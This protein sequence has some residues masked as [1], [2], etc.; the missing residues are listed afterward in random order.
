VKVQF[1]FTATELADVAERSAGRSVVLQERRRLGVA[2]WA[3]L[4]SFALFFALVG[5][6]WTRLLYSILIFI[7]LVL[8][9]PYVFPS[10]LRG[11]YRKYYREQLGGD[12]PFMCEVEIIPDG[13][14]C[15]Q[16]GVEIKRKWSSVVEVVDTPEGVEFRHKPTGMLVVR[17][18]AFETPQQRAEFIRLARDFI[19]SCAEQVI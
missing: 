10:G 12:G 6:V 18:R 11:Y 14:T 17:D 7:V 8:A 15:R 9:Y 1:E 5:E 3:A 2:G 13:I 4:I 19:A 16:I